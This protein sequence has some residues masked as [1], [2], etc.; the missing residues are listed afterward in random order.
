MQAV[1][2]YDLNTLP[3]SWKGTSYR[4]IA[5]KYINSEADVFED[6]FISPR[7][8]TQ[9]QGHSYNIFC[10]WEPFRE[11]ILSQWNRLS[12]DEIDAI[13]PSRNRLAELIQ[14]RYGISS[15]M[16]ENYLRNFERTLP[17]I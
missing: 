12:S 4:A 13:G 10:K 7:V 16:V 1:S 17:L 9:K 14:T 3:A 2:S 5:R 6:G 8:V 15:G 11:Q